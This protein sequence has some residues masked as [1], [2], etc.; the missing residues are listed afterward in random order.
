MKLCLGTILAGVALCATAD[1]LTWKATTGGNWSSAANWSSDG[2]HT[3][4]QSGDTIKILNL[5]SGQTYVNDIEGLSTPHLEFGGST[6][7]PY[8]VVRGQEITLT[9]GWNAA[10]TPNGRFTVRLPLVLTVQDGNPT[11]RFNNPGRWHQE[12]KVSGPG[13]LYKDGKGIMEIKGGNT[14][15]G[16]T[17]LA[18]SGGWLDPYY[19]T[20]G[21]NVGQTPLGA[22]D[23]VYEIIGSGLSR[24][25]ITDFPYETYVHPGTSK[26]TTSADQWFYGQMKSYNGNIR[27]T[28]Y[29]LQVDSGVNVKFTGAIEVP[30]GPLA[31]LY[32]TESG[33][34]VVAFN[35][36]VQ[37]Q[38]FNATLVTSLLPLTSATAKATFA[39]ENNAI[40]NLH[41]NFWDVVAG[42]RNAFGTNAV[43]RFGYAL[44]GRGI[45]DLA[46]FDQ[47]VDRI[48]LNDAYP[49]PT[50]GER[51]FQGHQIKSATPATLTLRA[52]ADATSDARFEGAVSLVWNPVAAST[53]TLSSDAARIHP[54]TGSLIVSNGTMVVAGTNSFP[55]VAAL[56]VADGAM[57]DGRGVI[58][59]AGLASEMS[60][61]LGTNAKWKLADGASI[62]L[63]SLVIGDSTLPG[64]VYTGDVSVEGAT[65]LDQ[66]EGA[67]MVYVE[68]T[69][70]EAVS[71]IWA[72]QGVD[73]SVATLANWKDAT[74]LPNFQ[75]G[76]LVATFAEA[77]TEAVLASGMNWKGL[78]FDAPNDF[79]VK[80]TAD[81]GLALGDGGIV[82]AV[83]ASGTRGYS[84]EAPVTIAADQSWVFPETSSDVSLALKGGLRQVAGGF[85]YTVTKSGDA[86][87]VLDLGESDYAGS[88]VISNGRVTVSGSLP[89]TDGTM[90]LVDTNAYLVLKNATIGQK[91]VKKYDQMTW[92]QTVANSTNRLLSGY[93]QEQ[94]QGNI[95]LEANSQLWVENVLGGKTGN[96]IYPKGAGELH[97]TNCVA[98]VGCVQPA[99]TV[100]IH[101]WNSKAFQIGNHFTLAA[102]C[103]LYTHAENAIDH[104]PICL[105]NGTVW[106]LCG[107]D[108][109]SGRISWMTGYTKAVI[110]S[111]EPA[112]L[113]VQQDTCS[114]SGSNRGT[115]SYSGKITGYV[116]LVK[117]GGTNNAKTEPAVEDLCLDGTFTAIG[118]VEV[119][120]GLLSFTNGTNRI[121]SWTTC[122]RA[123]AGSTTDGKGVKQT[124]VL[125][126]LHSQALGRQTDVAVN[127]GGVVRLGEGVCQKVHNLYFD[128][129][130]Q[131]LGTYGSSASSAKF[132]D[133]VHFAGTGVLNVLGDGQ[134]TML[135]FR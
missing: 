117:T 23:S 24:F 108:Q 130:K 88:F 123:T 53:L 91:V 57:F 4:P 119:V 40:A 79:A 26:A 51:A 102:G 69:S 37:V 121:G 94:Q 35:G 61:R 95:R 13:L 103:K 29:L 98:K 87:L 114:G 75:D 8:P 116:S 133:D 25:S 43:V 45:L 134:G 104:T 80:G 10:A 48:E 63:K 84:V 115:Q 122:T 93:V 81:A 33:K 118:E 96:Y 14:Y 68:Q 125:E 36:P 66:L 7:S 50:S 65:K 72:G 129:V 99:D 11:N 132:K 54:T 85:A 100:K 59:N 38:S 71:K 46:G 9:G 42:A 101:L 34:H 27:G 49:L 15:T 12:G 58:E 111:D 135:I 67:C 77:G 127:D 32:K 105:G 124:G 74:E 73:T 109:T 16:G 17:V 31:L 126:L 41:V 19:L 62:A 55:K 3:V 6:D 86:P 89:A 39:H 44:D 90:T 30:E 110:H 70:R 92:V 28:R 52:T 106:D 131:P 82:V 1:T 76:S 120:W 5:A 47:Q 22:V 78:R 18:G 64:G 97:V 56:E 60:V 2:S 113:T 112:T 128:S 107:K 21:D 20:S 83:P